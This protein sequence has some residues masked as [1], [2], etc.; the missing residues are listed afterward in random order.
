M[1]E[2]FP[3]ISTAEWEATIRA[4]LKGRLRQE[5][6]LA[7]GRRL[8]GKALLPARRL[9][10]HNRPGA[11]QRQVGA[12]EFGGY[13]QGRSSR[14]FAA[15]TGSNVRARSW[16]CTGRIGRQA[17]YLRVRRW[18]QL[19]HGNCQA[20]RG[21]ATVGANF[22]PVVIWSRT[23]LANKSLYD[24]SANLMLHHRSNE[25]D[26]WRLRLPDRGGS[27]VC[28]ALGGKFAARAR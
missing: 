8:C 7:D 23:S 3:P 1:W 10:R 21:A 28:A 20:P 5:T 4:D 22:Q 19:L 6:R 16:L 12:K 25:C 15:R 24:P 26:F 17:Q 9:A 2:E 14:L 18:R 13:S 27:A 11:I